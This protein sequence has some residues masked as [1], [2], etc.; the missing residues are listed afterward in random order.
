MK[1]EGN[2]LRR[3]SNWYSVGGEVAVDY[4]R[5]LKDLFPKSNNSGAEAL[6]GNIAKRQAAMLQEK[7]RLEKELRGVLEK[8]KALAELGRR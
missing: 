7:K 1:L 3:L 4:Q 6:P 8:E 2:E 5:V